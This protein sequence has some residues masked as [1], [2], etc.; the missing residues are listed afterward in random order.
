MAGLQQLRRFA[1]AGTRLACKR[2]VLRG[3]AYYTT[4]VSAPRP[5]RL[6]PGQIQSASI[7]A[8][9]RADEEGATCRGVKRA[10]EEASPEP[11]T[12][13]GL[14]FETKHY[15]QVWHRTR[16]ALRRMAVR[17]STGDDHNVWHVGP[18]MIHHPQMWL[19]QAKEAGY[20]DSDTL[21]KRGAVMIPRQEGRGHR[22]AELRSQIWLQTEHCMKV[23]GYDLPSGAVSYTHL[24][25]HRDRG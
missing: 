12:D 14:D 25:A 17:L 3:V 13:Q 7:S 24:R 11:T 22:L 5:E 16:T 4:N 15:M 10:A 23:R 19:Q 6:R 9:S 18:R 2:F 1:R 20:M 8:M 21:Q